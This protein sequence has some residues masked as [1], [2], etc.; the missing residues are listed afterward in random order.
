MKSLKKLNLNLIRID[1]AKLQ[2]EVDALPS[3]IKGELNNSLNE[4]VDADFS[5]K[6]KRRITYP[7]FFDLWLEKQKKINNSKRRCKESN[8]YAQQQNFGVDE[9]IKL[10]L[11]GGRQNLF[12]NSFK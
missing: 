11:K 8:S 12:V 10:R 1:I 5:T 3:I 2:Q 9:K 6:N 7:T 4:L